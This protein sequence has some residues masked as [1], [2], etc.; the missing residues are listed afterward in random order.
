M[1]T[2]FALDSF[3]SRT[4]SCEAFF[5]EIMRDHYIFQKK[6]LTERRL[7]IYRKILLM[8]QMGK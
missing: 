5:T 3:A 1:K 6:N 8:H 2:F 7:H 4:L